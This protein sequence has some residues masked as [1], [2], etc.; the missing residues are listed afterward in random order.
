MFR[1]HHVGC[2]KEDCQIRSV[3]ARINNSWT[4][5]GCYYTKCER[6]VKLSEI[7]S[8]WKRVSKFR[9]LFDLQ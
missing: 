9:S 6:F 1:S 8:E 2:N 5:V 4:K 7:S 3:Y